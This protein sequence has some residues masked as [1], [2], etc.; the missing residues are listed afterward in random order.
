MGDTRTSL[1]QTQIHTE[2]G[3]FEGGGIKKKYLLLRETRGKD[4]FLGRGERVRSKGG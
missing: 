3:L 4:F 1:M 2:G